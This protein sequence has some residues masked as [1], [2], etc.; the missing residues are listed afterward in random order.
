MNRVKA[1]GAPFT[2]R[3]S[4]INQASQAKPTRK[5]KG[6]SERVFNL[7]ELRP[8]SIRARRSSAGKNRWLLKLL[9]S[10]VDLSEIEAYYAWQGADRWNLPRGQHYV[11]SAQADSK[12]TSKLLSVEKNGNLFCIHMQ[13][14]ACQKVHSRLGGARKSAPD[15]D[16]SRLVQYPK[17]CGILR[18]HYL[19]VVGEDHR[20]AIAHFERDA[21]G[22][23]AQRKPVG[24]ERVAH[25][26]L[27]PRGE[28]STL[29]RGIQSRPQA[30]GC[31]ATFR[32]RKRQ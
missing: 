25:C 21:G 20:L 14:G 11:H 16:H 2:A 6:A 5:V 28:A 19:A 22:I 32:A 9:Q 3:R 1:A 27:W 7:S 30:N 10:L 17:A 15:A 12:R 4:S 24:A 26:V 31:N 18:L 23:L 8:N 13:Q 29:P